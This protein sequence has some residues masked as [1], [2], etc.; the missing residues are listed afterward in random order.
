M[1]NNSDRHVRRRHDLRR[2]RRHPDAIVIIVV[3]VA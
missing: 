3:I 2:C 1:C